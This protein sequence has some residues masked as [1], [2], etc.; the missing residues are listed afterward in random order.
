MPEG[1]LS[2]TCSERALRQIA[3]RHFY[4]ERCNVRVL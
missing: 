1:E 4:L 2:L 3:R